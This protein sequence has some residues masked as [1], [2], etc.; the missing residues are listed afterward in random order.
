MRVNLKWVCVWGG[1]YTV[2]ICF[3][4]RVG[5]I[6]ME[7]IEKLIKLKRTALKM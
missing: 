4:N 5:V 3:V 6:S 1:G 7:S 2:D